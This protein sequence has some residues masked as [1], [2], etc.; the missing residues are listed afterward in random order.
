MRSVLTKKELKNLRLV[1][2]T[3]KQ[4]RQIIRRFL[5]GHIEWANAVLEGITA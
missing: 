3:K 4:A 1:R 5:D 2:T